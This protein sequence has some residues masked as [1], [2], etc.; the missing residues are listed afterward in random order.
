MTDSTALQSLLN[1]A[2]SLEALCVT[3]G[4]QATIV[5]DSQPNFQLPDGAFWELP[6]SFTADLPA[7]IEQ[8]LQEKR[9]KFEDIARTTLPNTVSIQEFG[10]ATDA[11]TGRQISRMWETR[12]EA[13]MR[14]LRGSIHAKLKQAG[15]VRDKIEPDGKSAVGFNPVSST[16]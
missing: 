16:A 10:G 3:S 8:I 7:M 4:P 12:W 1:L 9:A 6:P 2:K 14:F 5:S 15:V 11:E 13:Y